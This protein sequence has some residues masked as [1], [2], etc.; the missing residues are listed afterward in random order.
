MSRSRVETGDAI[1]RHPLVLSDD[2]G[3]EHLPLFRA[4]LE[5]VLRLLGDLAFHCL[6]VFLRDLPVLASGQLLQH[7]GM[8]D[9]A[10]VR[11]A[12]HLLELRIRRVARDFL[13]HVEHLIVGGTQVLE[14]VDVHVLQIFRVDTGMLI[15]IQAWYPSL[16]PSASG[17]MAEFD[18]HADSMA[19]F[20]LSR[21]PARDP[22]RLLRCGD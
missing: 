1:V 18:Y 8:L 5:H 14:R 10:L 3:V 16:R 21:D 22:R 4:F 2:D 15:Q 9:D 19:G 6:A 12:E 13:D 11:V 20:Y 17:V 7:G